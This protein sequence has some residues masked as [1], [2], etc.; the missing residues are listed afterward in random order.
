MLFLT[1]SSPSRA[2]VSKDKK[3]LSRTS[4]RR[5]K[6]AIP[7]SAW[8]I[9]S[10]SWAVPKPS[11][12]SCVSPSLTS[13]AE[14]SLPRLLS[15]RLDLDFLWGS[16]PWHAGMIAVADESGMLAVPDSVRRLCQAAASGRRQALSGGCVRA[17]A[18]FCRRVRHAF[19]L[20]QGA[21]LPC[22]WL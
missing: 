6:T 2:T 16:I 1:S 3:L 21:E 13:A 12:S 9:L 14:G 8:L 10:S 19:G 11:G 15:L 20:S 22:L 17:Q 5:F 7:A 18:C 4:I